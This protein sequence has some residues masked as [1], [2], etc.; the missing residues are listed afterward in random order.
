MTNAP[1]KY[2]ILWLKLSAESRD[3]L[4]AAY[5][6]K[7]TVVY[8]DHVTLFPDIERQKVTHYIGE[9]AE[10]QVYASAFNEHIHA[11]RVQSTLPDTYGV[12]HITLSATAG[13]PPFASVA[14]LQADHTETQRDQP[15][16]LTGTI[17]YI[18]FSAK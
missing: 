13:T 11:V 5:P 7:Y 2:G 8:Y 6:P 15:L 14:M 9:Q 1:K 17:E 3:R 16:T 12:P 10:V 18:P 4:K